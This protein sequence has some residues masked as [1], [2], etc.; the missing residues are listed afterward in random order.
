MRLPVI[1]IDGQW[2]LQNGG[3]VRFRDR[4]VGELHVDSA[5]LIDENFMAVA[6]ESGKMLMLAAGTELRI[7]LTIRAGLDQALRPFLIE[8]SETPT[9][10]NATIGRRTRFVSIRLRGSTEPQLLPDDESDGLC[11]VFKGMDPVAIQSGFVELPN[12]HDLEP[13]PSLNQA[14]TRLSEVFE[15]WRKA[16]TGSIYERV[17]YCGQN[18]RWAPLKEL[19]DRAIEEWWNSAETERE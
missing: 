12:T 13:V 1:W 2:K 14:L 5:S 16:H 7:A 9:D 11:F 10:G 18:G 4:A 8:R 6:N 3:S 19:R 15:P 17:F